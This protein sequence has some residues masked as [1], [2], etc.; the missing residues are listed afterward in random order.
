MST[1]RSPLSPIFRPETRRGSIDVGGTPSTPPFTFPTLVRISSDMNANMT[2]GRAM[3]EHDGWLFVGYRDGLASID[4][5][6]PASPVVGE[7]FEPSASYSQWNAVASLPGDYVLAVEEDGTVITIDVSDPENMAVEDTDTHANLAASTRASAVT[8]GMI[9]GVVAVTN[10]VGCYTVDAS[11]P[12]NI[13]IDSGGVPAPD[14]TAVALPADGAVL[15]IGTEPD[16]TY[17]VYALSPTA[18]ASD[19]FLSPTLGEITHIAV[20]SGIAYLLGFTVDEGDYTMIVGTVDVSDPSD[21]TLL[22]TITLSINS[23]GA[24]GMCLDGTDVYVVAS[25]ASDTVTAVRVDAS[26]PYNLSEEESDTA[27]GAVGSPPRCESIVKVGGYIYYL[28]GNDPT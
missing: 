6:T 27:T 21:I 2:F 28:D 3:V 22:D 9:A 8:T 4:I 26:D 15:V 16:N 23:E 7:L 20:S 10:G 13:S 24:P 11:D 17:N 1:R 25:T 12:T 5:T 14:A 18:P 19:A